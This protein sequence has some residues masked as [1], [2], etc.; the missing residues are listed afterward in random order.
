MAQQVAV[1][2][3]AGSANPAEAY[4]THFVPAIFGPW[5]DELIRRV[6]PEPGE[7][8]L[9]V[10]C[11][12]GAVTRQVAPLVG[13]EGTLIGYDISPAM[14]GV[15]RSQP[16]PAGAA[17]VWREGRAEELPF[18]G[19]SFDAVFCQQGLQFSPDRLAVVREIH[20]VLAPDGR[21]GISVWRGV[22]YQPTFKLFDAAVEGHLGIQPDD[23][24]FS[25][26]DP[27]ELRSLLADAGFRRVSIETVTRGVHFPSANGFVR[28]SI[29]AAAAVVP[30]EI[31]LEG[32]A[33]EE[34]LDTISRE[35]EEPLRAYRDGA[36]L[37]FPMTAN[38]AVAE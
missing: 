25:F 33:R 12:T 9:D 21:A 26:G 20:R 8:V 1:A 36:G 16:A 30:D 15:A 2:Q 13:V 10:A 23:T 31:K 29:L 38:V 19:G 34:L 11:G 27:D 18:A 24:P 4:Q 22:E 6:A 28:M 7:R 17:I 5:A 32:E 37:T 35:L 3:E 14:L